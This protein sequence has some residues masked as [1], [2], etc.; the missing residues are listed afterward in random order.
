MEYSQSGL[1][2]TKNLV[3]REILKNLSKRYFSLQSFSWDILFLNQNSTW[4]LIFFPFWIKILNWSEFKTSGLHETW[5]EI[6]LQFWFTKYF[7]I[8]FVSACPKLIS[9][10]GLPVNSKS[11]LL[12][13]QAQMMKHF[14]GQIFV[15]TMTQ[16]RVSGFLLSKQT[17]EV[18][19]IKF[20]QCLTCPNT[21]LAIF[22]PPQ[23]K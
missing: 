19:G 23:S 9:Y 10:L 22:G 16:K 4:F 8:C 6:F 15:K 2:V 17:A 7:E 20:P 18:N 21:K 3:Q 12:T 14:R 5:N 13:G 11:K 1:S